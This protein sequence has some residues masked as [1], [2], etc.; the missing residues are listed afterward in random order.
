MTLNYTTLQSTVLD[1]AV[2]PELTTEV[3]QFIRECE[4]MI[5][6]R[7]RALELRS[8]LDESDRVTGGIY[9]LSGQVQRL[10][11]VYSSSSD[12]PLELV[13]LGALRA[14]PTSA[15]VTRYAVVGQTIEFR[16]VPGTDA[17]IELVYFGWPDPLAT[18]ATNEL[19]TNFEDLYIHGT[20]EALYT[21]T[22]DLEL[23]QYHGGKAREIAEAVN[24]LT[25][26]R[27]S[28]GSVAPA[29]NFGHVRIG[30]GY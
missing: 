29:Y 24:D 16:G 30:R 8:T 7:V 11:A 26:G 25:A 14:V 3:L 23:A 1:R 27:N 21:Y 4:S 15:D 17:E 22:Q 19:L 28:G 9:N 5:R 20:L 12:A 10:R 2:R 13:G 6:T 18:T